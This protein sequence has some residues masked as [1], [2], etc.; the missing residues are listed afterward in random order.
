MSDSGLR[1]KKDLK[2]RESE[3]EKFLT[4]LLEEIQG[5]TLGPHHVGVGCQG[6]QLAS[7]PGTYAFLRDGEA[8]VL[9]QARLDWSIQTHLTTQNG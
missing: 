4:G 3:I 8:S 2:L 5:M 9:F 1:L 7:G 6:Q